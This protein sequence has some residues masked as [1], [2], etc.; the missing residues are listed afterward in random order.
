MKERTILH[1]DLNNFYASV[2]CFYNPEIRGLPVVVCGD[3]EKRHGIVLAKNYIAKS[4]GIVTGDVLWQARQKCPGLVAVKADFK[5]YLRYSDM[6]RKI[7]RDYAFRIESFGIDECWLDVTGD[8][9]KAI[10]DEIRA[11]IR[12]EM[13]V[14]ASVG[15]SW[16]KIYA[17]LGSDMKKPDATT[18]ITKENYK[19][20]VYPLAV[21]NLLMVGRA[22]TQ[23]LN[24]YGVRTIGQLAMQNVDTMKRRFGKVGEMLWRYANGFDD[25]EVKLDG[26]KDKPKSVSN[27]VTTPRDLNNIAQVRLLVTLLSESVALK[28]REEGLKANVVSLYIRDC[29][30]KGWGKQKKLMRPSMLSEDFIEGAMALFKEYEFV[31]PIRAVGVSV[32]MLV[33]KNSIFQ[34]DFFI[35]PEELQKK[36]KL[37]KVIYDIKNHYGKEAICRAIKFTDKQL[38]EAADKTHG[39]LP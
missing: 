17:K 39:F 10:A 12:S 29:N 27:S 1:C 35:S 37:E 14:T 9:G 18:V 3:E 26:Q 36:E 7:Y 33:E 19:D 23:K 25:S 34:R 30:L 24:R 15:V 21:E 6:A 8:D 38:A 22:T 28:L 4:Y 16:N 2:E 5:K 32:S 31:Q 11:R 20:T 13:G